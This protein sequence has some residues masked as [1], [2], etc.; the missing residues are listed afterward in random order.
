LGAKEIHSDAKIRAAFHE[1]GHAVASIL[2]GLRVH[3]VLLD[4]VFDGAGEM[5][6]RP[7]PKWYRPDAKCISQRTRERMDAEIICLLA[8]PAAEL[9]IADL[10]WNTYVGSSRDFEEAKHLAEILYVSKDER[11]KFVAQ[12]IL[13][14]DSLISGNLAHW[15]AIEKLANELLIK[16][17]VPGPRV[18]RILR[19]AKKA[20]SK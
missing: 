5:H 3:V 6:G 11:S 14:T 16:Q 18:G 12:A 2:M 4:P 9:A 8:G 13:R 10:D 15:A 20:I 19:V 17:F 7:P 1:A